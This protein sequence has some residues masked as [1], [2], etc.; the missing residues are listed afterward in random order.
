MATQTPNARSTARR[1]EKEAQRRAQAKR[2]RLIY[3]GVGA[4]LLL[5]IVVVAVATVGETDERIRLSDVVG[6][7]QIEGEPL[8]PLPEEGDDPAIGM[9]APVLEGTD[10]DGAPITVGDGAQVLSFVAHWCPACDAELPEVAAWHN[11]GG[12]PQGVD[13]VLVSTNM[14]DSRTG[15]PPSAWFADA[16]YTGDVLMDDGNSSSFQAYGLRATPSWV[17]IN[18]AGEVLFRASGML[19]PAQFDDLGQLAATG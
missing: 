17:V 6:S 14:D 19:D 2:Q 13:L 10:L 3:G 15:W 12:P 8:P 7:P 11:E 9:T 5:I 16:G 18:D 4:V 1:E